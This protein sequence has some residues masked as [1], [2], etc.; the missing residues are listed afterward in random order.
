M[1]ALLRSADWLPVIR[2]E[3]LDS[4][5]ARGGSSVKF[6]VPLG[7]GETPV[8]RAEIERLAR[9][10]G[11]IFVSVDAASTRVHMIDQVFFSVAEQIPWR[12]TVRSVIGRRVTSLGLAMPP[13]TA[14]GPLFEAIA[15]ANELDPDYVQ[16]ELRRKVVQ[17]VFREYRLAKDFRVAMTQL[18]LA[19]LS[20]G[21]E[22]D[23]VFDTLRDWLT[24]ANRTVSAVKPFQIYTRIHRANARFCLESAVSWVSLA[25]HAGT[26]I[27]MD[28]S[29]LGL[30][31]NP[32]DDRIFYSRAA[33]VDAYEVLR[34]FIDTSDRLT[35]CMIIVLAGREFLDDDP[36]SRGLGGYAAL[37]FRIFDEV[38]DRR[39]VNPFASLVRLDAGEGMGV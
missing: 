14:D 18:I 37:K 16:L 24:G 3:Y 23:T 27:V 34:Q 33:A 22:A 32:R 11:H 39:I 1:T 21:H 20:G 5:V 12:Q 17:Q 13:D 15:H 31:R 36:G 26:T 19:E 9:D 38:R 7:D 29:R 2:D 10:S 8:I 25:G 35:S 30:A 6:A 4:Y 28:V